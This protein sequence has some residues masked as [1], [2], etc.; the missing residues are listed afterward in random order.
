MIRF[1]LV[2]ALFG[3]AT[4]L[5]N[6]ISAA[7]FQTHN[8]ALQFAS[9]LPHGDKIGHFLLMGS[10]ALLVNLAMDV[11]RVNIRGRWFLL[12]SL[13]VGL[14]VTLE[15]VSQILVPA[16][17]FSFYDLAADYLGIY[18]FG[19]LA[20]FLANARIPRWTAARL[21]L[22]RKRRIVRGTAR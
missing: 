12:G 17:T 3:Y 15:E 22:W 5:Y 14:I 21:Y 11:R 13:I 19:R 7:N 4:F 20:I 18:L 1:F 9:N 16:R 8:A 10:L 2:T 6:A